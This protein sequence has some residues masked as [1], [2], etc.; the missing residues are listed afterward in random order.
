MELYFLPYMLSFVSQ[1]VPCGFGKEGTGT[2]VSFSFKK[3]TIGHLSTLEGRH[4]SLYKKNEKTE[5]KKTLKV[6]KKLKY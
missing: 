1:M 4:L 5:N 6:N 3:L 2:S